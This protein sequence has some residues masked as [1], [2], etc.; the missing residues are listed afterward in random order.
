MLYQAN[1]QKE[2]TPDWNALVLCKDKSDYPQSLQYQ[3]VSWYH[4]YLQHPGYIN[5]KE[6]LQLQCIGQIGELLFNHM[7][8]IAD[9]AKYM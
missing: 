1:S 6:I 2:E 3:T 7:S 8:K 9:P 5:L 4:N